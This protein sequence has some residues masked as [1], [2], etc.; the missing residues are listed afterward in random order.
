MKHVLPAFSIVVAALAPAIAQERDPGLYRD[1]S[2]VRKLRVVCSDRHFGRVDD[3]IAEIPSGRITGAVVSM[4]LDEGV[5][6]VVV[7][8]EG[9]EY[10]PRSNLL[11]MA[12]CLQDG[13]YPAFDAAAVKITMEPAKEGAAKQVVGQVL[14]SRLQ[15][16]RIDLQGGGAGWAQ[17]ATIE[18]HSGHVAFVDVASVKERAGDSQIH[19]VPWSALRWTPTTA[20]GGGG[21]AM[22]AL[23]KTA[24]QL[25]A[26][27][28]LIEVIVQ[29]PLYRSTVYTYFAAPRPAYD[30]I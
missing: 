5:R 19:P 25:A 30:R 17:S 7:P 6:T 24:Q 10:E 9:L 29:N 8:Y 14:V 13:K 20:D 15:S 28:N 21:A 22:L 12:A 16:S 4:V 3:L 23:A 11:Q 1:V 2:L 18:L 26:A 27:P